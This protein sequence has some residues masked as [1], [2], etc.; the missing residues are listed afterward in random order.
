MKI[1]V[2]GNLANFD[3]NQRCHGANKIP[4][5]K[6][7][8]SKKLQLLFKSF[9]SKDSPVDSLSSTGPFGFLLQVNNNELQDLCI[10]GKLCTTNISL[11]TNLT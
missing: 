9:G 4:F 2:A 11:E 5:K 1:A 6:F 10:L 8:I 3:A 7:P